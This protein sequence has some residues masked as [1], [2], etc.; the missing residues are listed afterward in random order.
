MNAREVAQAARRSIEIAQERL[1][2]G[3]A[4]L[5]FAEGSRSRTA[6]MVPFLAGVSRYLDPPDVWVLPVGIAGSEA[7][8]P[9][10]EDALTPVHVATRVGPPICASVLLERAHGDRQLAMDAI[11]F[12]VAAQLP[13]SYRGAYQDQT[14]ALDE[15]HR[16][17]RELSA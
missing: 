2:L 3:D 4:L 15:A 12:A 11:G 10:T 6:A 13:P 1:R 8:F 5:V 17:W 9:I 14:P 7:L 16:L